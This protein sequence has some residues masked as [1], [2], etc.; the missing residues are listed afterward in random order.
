MEN[1]RFLTASD[2]AACLGIS[3][4]KAY[5]IIRELNTELKDQGYLTMAGKVS[6]SYFFQKIYGM[7]RGEEGQ[8]A[9]V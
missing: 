2:V 6:S 8:N 7:N 3:V 1:K 9:R 5:R 4:S